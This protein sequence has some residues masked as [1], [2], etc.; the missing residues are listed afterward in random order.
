MDVARDQ[1]ESARATRQAISQLRN[2]GTPHIRN[3]SLMTAAGRLRGTAFS[4]S[5]TTRA[6]AF[7][8]LLAHERDTPSSRATWRSRRRRGGMASAQHADSP[9]KSTT[10]CAILRLETHARMARMRF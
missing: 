8:S 9:L 10:K 3:L 7:A 6:G 1:P 4:N 2:S 5:A